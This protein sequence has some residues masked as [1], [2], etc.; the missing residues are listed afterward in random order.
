[1]T[2]SW[3]AREYE[4]AGASCLSVLTDEKFFQG[5]LEYLKLIREAVKLP[6]L[7]KDF[8]IDERQIL[9]AVEWGAD[10][11]LLIVA[12]LS[13]SRLRQFHA[14]ATEAGLAAL[15]EVHDEAELDRA[16]AAG[17]QIIGVNNRDLKTFK[18]DLATTE[19][20]AARL[21]LPR[22]ASRLRSW[23]PK[24]ASTLAR[25]SSGWRSAAPKPYWWASH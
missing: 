20:L 8:I 11:I 12:I 25:M 1:M 17:A 6:L 23:S 22:H 15:V 16:L 10:A 19:R 4:A 3:I 5:S 13:D 18:V 7:R 21:R 24:A 2:P 14:L 9:E